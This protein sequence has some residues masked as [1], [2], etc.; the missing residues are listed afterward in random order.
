MTKFSMEMLVM[1]MPIADDRKTRILDVIQKFKK[2]VEE[3]I[4]IESQINQKSKAVQKKKEEYSEVA[5]E[6]QI[7]EKAEAELFPGEKK[8]RSRTREIEEEVRALEAEI[9][10][11]QDERNKIKTRLIQS[12][13]DLPIP[14]D[15]DK[16]GQEE[17]KTIFPFFDDTELG[18]TAINV[19]CKLLE[20]EKLE[21]QGVNILSDKVFVEGSSINEGITKLASGIKAYRL[22]LG[23]ILE[24]YEQIDAMVE[25]AIR[26]DLYPRILKILLTEKEMSTAD[27]AEK[28]GENERRVYDSC[29][30]LTR[31][32]GL[33]SPNPLEPTKSGKW[34]LTISGEILANRLLEKYPEKAEV[35]TASTTS[36]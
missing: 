35:E 30:N 33:W 7:R 23:E 34:T 3:Y 18:E 28:L 1:K 17:G 25:R 11:L 16:C 31:G 19:M 20:M 22:K 14:A 24:A 27:I 32:R 4:S 13:Y 6:E 29:Y 8:V 26:S 15:L 9:T 36:T 5:Y 10:S 21:F 12:M 2:D